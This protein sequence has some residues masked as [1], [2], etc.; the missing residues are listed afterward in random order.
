MIRFFLIV[1]KSCQ[2]RFARYYEQDEP[3]DRPT[4][5]LDVARGCITRKQSQ[6]TFS[7]KNI[8]GKTVKYYF[9]A[10]FFHCKNIK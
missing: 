2:T 10:Y 7:W 6:V 9:R 8:E 5:E 4:F 1:N 3:N